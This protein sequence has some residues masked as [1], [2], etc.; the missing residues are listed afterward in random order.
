MIFGAAG[1]LLRNK[2]W[3]NED[4]KTPGNIGKLIL[5]EIEQN[6]L[7]GATGYHHVFV[8]PHQP[9]NELVSPEMLDFDLHNSFSAAAQ[10]Q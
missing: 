2:Y 3:V 7:I 4:G 8:I 9:T 10:L 6:G 1:W 5:R